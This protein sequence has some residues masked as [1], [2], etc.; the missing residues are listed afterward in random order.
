VSQ[1]WE[2]ANRVQAEIRN[3]ANDHTMA[4]LCN[5]FPLDRNT[6]VNKTSKMAADIALAPM[7]DPMKVP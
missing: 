1:V 6:S 7:A 3:E 4:N 5:S 2:I